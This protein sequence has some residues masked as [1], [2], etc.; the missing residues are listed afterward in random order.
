MQIEIINTDYA[1]STL[2]LGHFSSSEAKTFSGFKR[3]LREAC[4]DYDDRSENSCDNFSFI[5]A[6][7][8]ENTK[9]EIVANLERLGFTCPT[10]EPI[11]NEKNN[12]NVKFW[13]LDIPTFIKNIQKGSGV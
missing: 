6:S 8:S 10:K 7:T 1:C 12:T 3:E 13:T 11:F 9:P 4:S 5:T 2:I